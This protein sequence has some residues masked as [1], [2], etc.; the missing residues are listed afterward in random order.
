MAGDKVIFG[1]YKGI[2]RKAPV[3]DII[4]CE[5]NISISQ[6]ILNDNNPAWNGTY[7]WLSKF[8]LTIN[9]T[10]KTITVKVKL[11]CDTED[12]NKTN[13]KSA[14]EGKWSNKKRLEVVKEGVKSNYRIGVEIEWMALASEAHYTI[15]ANQPEATE[16]GRSGVG[17][18]T[19]MIGWGVNDNTD[20][21]H[22]FGH[23]LGNKDEYFTIDGVAYG[24]GR[25]SG[26]GIMN[27]PSENPHKRHFDTIKKKVSEA[28]NIAENQCTVID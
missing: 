26:K 24:A 13:W 2:S 20:V 9:T 18:T 27:N 3:N 15:T 4:T 23:M 14:V 6:T 11:F 21:P 10:I 12:A 19:S 17:G 5:A 28:L 7:G 1:L 25:Q 8:T 16:G 22:E